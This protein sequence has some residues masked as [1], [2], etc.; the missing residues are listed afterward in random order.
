MRE[1][2]WFRGSKY[3][4][5]QHAAP[6][7]VSQ[8]TRNVAASSRAESSMVEDSGP[9]FAPLMARMGQDMVR[10]IVQSCA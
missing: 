10:S 9:G 4:L 6:A 2:R 1:P 3:C 8:V 5:P 7:A